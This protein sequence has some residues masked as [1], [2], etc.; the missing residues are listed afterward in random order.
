MTHDVQ[1]W[2]FGW[3]NGKGGRPAGDFVLA[4][5]AEAHEKAAVE[6]AR[7]ALTLVPIQRD[8]NRTKPHDDLCSCY[9]DDEPMCNRL[10]PWCSCTRIDWAAERAIRDCIAAV[11]AINHV[12]TSTGYAGRFVSER[13]VI[14]ALRALLEKP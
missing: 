5:E 2:E 14:A 13:T 3:G 1:R 12:E 11:Y 6:A 10:C 4:S 7:H 9:M 8:I